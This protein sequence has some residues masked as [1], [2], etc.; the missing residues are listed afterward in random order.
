MQADLRGVVAV[1][2]K[3]PEVAV[4]E[5]LIVAEEPLEDAALRQ[6]LR[7]RMDMPRRTNGLSQPLNRLLG[8]PP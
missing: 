4:E 3:L 7:P 1:A 6:P 8:I 5:Q 2:S